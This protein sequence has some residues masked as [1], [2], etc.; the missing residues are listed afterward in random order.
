[1]LA[2]YVVDAT[3]SGHTIEEVAL[4][5]LG[6]KALTQEDVCGTGQKTIALPHLPAAAILNF[7]GERSD[8][9][10]QLADKLAARLREHG[11]E[12]LYRD[13]ELPL[14]PVLADIER[15]GIR[16]DQRALA[17]QSQRIEAELASRSSRIFRTGWRRVQHQLAETAL[18][19]SLREAPTS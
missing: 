12:R 7:A 6:Y 14:V 2:S 17:S 4:E 16:I 19:D 9:A 18:G 10:W 3:R 8:L 13:L 11:L 5:H 1:M 15:H